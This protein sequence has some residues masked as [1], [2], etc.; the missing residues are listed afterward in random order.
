[1]LDASAVYE[2]L[3]T[4]DLDGARSALSEG[5][6]INEA[7]HRGYTLLQ[8]AVCR[9]EHS[10]VSWLLEQG[11]DPDATSIGKPATPLALAIGLGDDKTAGILLH[12]AADPNRLDGHGVPPL[13]HAVQCPAGA[14]ELV[15]MLLAAGADPD[16]ATPNGDTP[17]MVAV[18]EGRAPVVKRLGE[19]AANPNHANDHGETVAFAAAM[20]QPKVAKTLLDA[21]PS[22]DLN[23]KSMS[24]TLPITRAMDPRIIALFINRGADPNARSTNPAQEGRTVLMTIIAAARGAGASQEAAVIAPCDLLDLALAKGADP[25]MQDD[26]GATAMS[27]AVHA[28]AHGV[29]LHQQIVSMYENGS[30]AAATALD[31]VGSSAYAAALSL[32]GEDVQ[33]FVSALKGMDVPMLH[34]VTSGSRKELQPHPLGITVWNRNLEASM[35]LVA[36]GARWNDR[37]ADGSTPSHAIVGLANALSAAKSQAHLQ[38][39]AMV[40]AAPPVQG[41]KKHDATAEVDRAAETWRNWLASQ[42]VDFTTPD[43]DGHALLAAM[44]PYVS[45]EWVTWAVESGANPDTA[46]ADNPDASAW[47]VAINHGQVEALHAMLGHRLAASPGWTPPL[48]DWVLGLSDEGNRSSTLEAFGSLLLHPKAAGWLDVPDED[49]NTPLILAAA[50]GQTDVVRMLLAAGASA[51]AANQAG[52]TALHHATAQQDFVGISMLVTS[53][54]TLDATTAAGVSIRDILASH[55]ELGPAVLTSRKAVWEPSEATR[56]AMS[57]PASASAGKARHRRTSP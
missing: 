41:E 2:M 56:K 24:G 50:T 38:N 52:E 27:Y 55:A 23:H 44:I 45:T 47:M 37:G 13:V 8:W 42:P 40:M 7:T 11:A 17:L 31:K 46:P 5:L 30:F 4:G 29:S 57:Q 39:V 16:A 3:S 22:L 25:Q 49:G 21:F 53:G 9:K 20:A 48:A 10:I 51:K 54:A 32:D 35:A 18:Q 12:H 34:P 33:A 14:L 1:M 36:A 43:A 15:D 26:D 6:R 19:T 28:A